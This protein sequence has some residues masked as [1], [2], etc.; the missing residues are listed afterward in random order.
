MHIPWLRRVC[1][2]DDGLVIG[3]ATPEAC[4]LSM[5]M[6]AEPL[7]LGFYVTSPKPA[8]QFKERPTAAAD[9]WSEIEAM[10]DAAAAALE[11]AACQRSDIDLVIFC[12]CD[13][14]APLQP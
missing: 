11:A 9:E 1:L 8:A 7:T 3:A 2:C 10:R 5:R 14:C 13:K 12:G 6:P 4:A